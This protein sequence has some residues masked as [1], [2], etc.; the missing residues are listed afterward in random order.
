MASYQPNLRVQAPLGR[1]VDRVALITGASRGIGRAV[2]QAFRGEGALLALVSRSGEAIGRVAEEMPGPGAAPLILARDI[3]DAAAIEEIRA[4]ILMRWGRLDILV[5][6]AAELGPLARVAELPQAAWDRVIDLNLTANYRLIRAF[7]DL[8]RA[9]N[10]GRAIFVTS[11]ISRGK[12][13][14]G[15]YAASKAG[16]AWL[17]AAY[18]AEVANSRLRVNLV[19]PGPTRTAMRA[20]AMP[21]E[22]PATLRPPEAVVEAFIRLAA[23]DCTANGVTVLA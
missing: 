6:N 3:T 19:D 23:A 21:D 11:A 22:D 10:A 16:L 12:A 4:A 14:R 1:L 7:D 8:L 15:A 2:A 18:A 13:L 5:G 9:S 20:R 17:V